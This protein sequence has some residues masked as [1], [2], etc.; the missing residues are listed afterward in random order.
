MNDDSHSN[1]LIFHGVNYCQLLNA[2]KTKAKN[3]RLKILSVILYLGTTDCQP[4]I[5][6]RSKM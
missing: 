6:A 4:V 2:L 1:G 5:M 3:R